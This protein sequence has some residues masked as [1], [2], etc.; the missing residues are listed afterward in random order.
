MDVPMNHYKKEKRST[1][2]R[3]S[4][5]HD[6]IYLYQIRIEYPDSQLIHNLLVF[7]LLLLVFLNLYFFVL[8]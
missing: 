4:G 3:D 8:S 1:V 6:L 2:I 5:G 7:H